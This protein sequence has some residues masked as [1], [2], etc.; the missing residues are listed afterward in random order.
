MLRAR[1]QCNVSLIIIAITLSSSNKLSQF[2]A[3]VHYR[4]LA[5]G[6]YSEWAKKLHHSTLQ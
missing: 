5:T 3:H 6:G 1:K 2:L 4:I